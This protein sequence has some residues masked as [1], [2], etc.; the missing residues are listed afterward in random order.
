MESTAVAR[1][2]MS[3]KLAPADYLQVLQAWLA[4]WSVLEHLLVHSRPRDLDIS[5]SPSLRLPQL[6]QDIRE[7]RLALLDKSALPGPLVSAPNPDLLERLDLTTST[8]AGWLGLAYVMQGSRLGSALVVSHLRRAL[9]PEVAHCTAF[10]SSG[11]EAPQG[12]EH[13]WRSWLQ[14]LDDQLVTAFQQEQAVS[15][16]AL[17][18]EF[19]ACA[20]TA[21]A[22]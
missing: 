19:I 4:A 22:E 11:V 5:R 9:P 3:G 14:W 8:R 2:L 20:W 13:H 16:A 1:R 17:T 6:C 15:A 7:V 18:F 21:R 10:F 12:V